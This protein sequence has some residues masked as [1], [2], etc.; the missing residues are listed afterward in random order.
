[1]LTSWCN[2]VCVRVA[3]AFTDRCVGEDGSVVSTE[4][5]LSRES[6]G[7]GVGDGGYF[8]VQRQSEGRLAR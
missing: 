6:V 7:L 5:I 1:M 8:D 4:A 3:G 2:H